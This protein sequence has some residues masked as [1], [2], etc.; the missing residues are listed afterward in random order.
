MKYIEKTDEIV[1]ANEIDGENS[2]AI[3]K[4]MKE[5]SRNLP[6]FEEIINERL[7]ETI[8]EIK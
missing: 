8:N 3:L 7:N 1:K 2:C 6:A 4:E 5:I